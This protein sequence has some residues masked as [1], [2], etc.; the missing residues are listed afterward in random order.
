MIGAVDLISTSQ[1]LIQ[2]CVKTE[3]LTSIWIS[4]IYDSDLQFSNRES[5]PG[6]SNF[7][8][9][10]L[11][12]LINSSQTQGIVNIDSCFRLNVP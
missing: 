3:K 10:E 7:E 8:F 12:L 11:F 5:A 2:A 6:G 1:S 4:L 9:Q